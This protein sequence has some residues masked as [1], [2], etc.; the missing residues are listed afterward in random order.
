MNTVGQIR[1]GDVLLVPVEGVTPPTDAKTVQ[2]AILAEGELTGHAHRL[3][4][5]Q[6]VITWDDFVMV[7]AG[8]P[9]AIQHEDHDPTPVPVVVPGVVYRV[10]VQREYS[11]NDQ[12]RRVAD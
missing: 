11:L 12:W 5:K 6:G 9:G 10:V 8:A 3:T 1:Q 7:P 2:T 4:A